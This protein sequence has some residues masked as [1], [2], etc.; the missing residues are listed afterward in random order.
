MSAFAARAGIV[1]AFIAWERLTDRPMLD[2]SVFRN[3][4]FSA[5]SVSI[6]LVFFALMGVTF[7]LTAHL[8]SV[9]GCSAL[10]AG[11]RTLPIA[12][13]MVLASKLAVGL[14]LRLGTKLSVTL[15]LTHVAARWR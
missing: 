5:A 1:A 2:V 6:A 9:L 3:V 8:H 12:I 10:Q 14:T 7:F 15:G 13:G 4:R 11:V